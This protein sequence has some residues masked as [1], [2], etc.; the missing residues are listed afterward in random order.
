MEVL[1]VDAKCEIFLRALCTWG[2]GQR[3]GRV[4]WLLLVP[5]E[6]G[7]YVG[8]RNPF[9]LLWERMEA[10]FGLDALEDRSWDAN[11]DVARR[12]YAIRYKISKISCK[13]GK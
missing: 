4:R 9:S 2:L 10:W 11:W 13:L 1:K 7:G 6:R 8:I 3:L 12:N 5:V